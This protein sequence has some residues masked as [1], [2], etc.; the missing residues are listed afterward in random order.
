MLYY[1]NVLGE[2]LA[3]DW[4]GDGEE[5]KLVLSTLPYDLMR[6]E[7]GMET[8]LMKTIATVVAVILSAALFAS[9][10]FAE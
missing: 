7:A 10:V 1:Y 9:G 3:V 4:V 5:A 8:T 2:I 6:L